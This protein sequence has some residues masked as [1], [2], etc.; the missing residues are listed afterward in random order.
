M[1]L[2]KPICFFVVAAALIG[3]IPRVVAQAPCAEVDHD[4]RD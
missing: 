2:V 3:V 4:R 1:N